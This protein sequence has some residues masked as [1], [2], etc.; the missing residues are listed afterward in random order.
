MP[1]H[2]YLATAS[3]VGR[4]GYD[5][6]DAIR[7]NPTLAA[8]GV[9]GLFFDPEADGLAIEAETEAELGRYIAEAV[10][11]GLLPA[12]ALERLAERVYHVEE[13]DSPRDEPPFPMRRIWRKDGWYV[14]ATDAESHPD[15]SRFSGAQLERHVERVLSSAEDAP[16]HRLEQMPSELWVSARSIADLERIARLL[17]LPGLEDDFGEFDDPGE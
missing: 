2:V 6:E 14:A 4:S 15:W 12:E 3:L 11:A 1:A 17:G 16:E 13:D 5:V 9:A 8:L 7:R 10:T